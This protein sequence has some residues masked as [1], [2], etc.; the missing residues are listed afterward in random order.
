[1][2]LIF[3]ASDR[4]ISF[5]KNR[6]DKCIPATFYGLNAPWSWGSSWI[7]FAFELLV[8]R[9][10]LRSTNACLLDY[11]GSVSVQ[12]LG[13]IIGISSIV[14]TKTV[15]I[16]RTLVKTAEIS[17]RDS[18]LSRIQDIATARFGLATKVVPPR[19][20]YNHQRRTQSQL[21]FCPFGSLD[22]K[23]L[24]S[25]S[26]E[27][28]LISCIEFGFVVVIPAAISEQA[29]QIN[30]LLKKIDK[31]IALSCRVLIPSSIRE[32]EQVIVDS[33]FF[34][35]VDSLGA[36][37][38]YANCIDSITIY[39]PTDFRLFPPFTV[40]ESRSTHLTINRR[41]SC[42]PCSLHSCVNE[43]LKECFEIDAEDLMS[44]L[45]LLKTA[46]LDRAA[47]RSDGR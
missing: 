46:S 31:K 45:H 36:N 9:F 32:F 43:S 38:A 19:L 11:R 1:M 7:K 5:L 26:I 33:D 40:D 2:N 42:K 29:D 22:L 28:I 17:S 27:K 12:T 35:G 30:I 8:L 47:L 41:I 23:T 18:F 44:K 25:I 13:L 6:Q 37:L 14:T 4:A 15:P 39:G 10:R 16:L 34:I 21:V 24:P 3:V 20:D